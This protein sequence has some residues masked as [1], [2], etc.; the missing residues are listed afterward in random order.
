MIRAC[1]PPQGAEP[2]VA[3][4][5]RRDEA[6]IRL[7]LE[8]EMRAGEVTSLALS[9]VDLA[10]GVATVRLGKGGKGRAVPLGPD[11]SPALVRYL[12]LRRWHRLAA[13]EGVGSDLPRSGVFP[14]LGDRGHLAPLHPV[15]GSLARTHRPR[16]LGTP[17]QWRGLCVPSLQPARRR[18]ARW[19]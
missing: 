10:N 6:M 17:N 4:R 14:R 9:D 8:A 11:A 7:M 5:H 2:K 18:R 16:P 12:R 13:S 19:R 1:T 3:L 15:V